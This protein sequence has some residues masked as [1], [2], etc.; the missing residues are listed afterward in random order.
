MPTLDRQNVPAV[1]ALLAPDCRFQ[2]GNLPVVVGR[3]AIGQALGAFF[4]NVQAVQHTITDVFE[5]PE[6]A[7]YRG[8]VTYTRPNGSNLTVPVCDVFALRPDGLVA[9]YCI[10]IDWSVL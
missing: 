6:R 1:L 10:Y 8:E 5:G 3:E 7:V 2:A 9:E 4:S